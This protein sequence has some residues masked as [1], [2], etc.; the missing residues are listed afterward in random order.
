MRIN[1][2]WPVM[3]A[4]AHLL[5]AAIMTPISAAV[6]FVGAVLE[7]LTDVRAALEKIAATG[8]QLVQKLNFTSDSATRHDGHGSARWYVSMLTALNR[9]TPAAPAL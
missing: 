9:E 3:A 8:R 5:C 4:V 7:P 2:I 1:R 6:S